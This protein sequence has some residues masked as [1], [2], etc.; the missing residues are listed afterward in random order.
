MIGFC[1]LTIA[2]SDAFSAFMMKGGAGDLGFVDVKT[3]FDLTDEGPD[4]NASIL[5]TSCQNNSL[6]SHLQFSVLGTVVT[7]HTSI[8]TLSIEFLS[9]HN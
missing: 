6:L 7:V 1:R 8:H 4:S 9:L 2:V 3:S 5:L